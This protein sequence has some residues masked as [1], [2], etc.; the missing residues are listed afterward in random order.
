MV[1]KVIENSSTF[2]QIFSKINIIFFHSAGK[3]TVARSMGKILHGYGVLASDRVEETSATKLIGTAVGLTKDNVE[4]A[5]NL[6]RGGVL[7]IDEAYELGKGGYGDEGMTQLLSMLTMSEFD[8]GKTV[9]ILAGYTTQ[10][11]E[12]L[13]R[14]PGL[15][16]R[17]QKFVNFEDW[18]GRKCAK[19][20]K[21]MAEKEKP[22]PMEILEWDPIENFLEGEFEEARKR[23]GWANAR[24]VILVFKMIVGERDKRIAL[25]KTDSTQPKIIFE[26]VKIA[27]D[28]FLKNRPILVQSQKKLSD[29]DG[30][31]IRTISANFVQ[32]QHRLNENMNHNIQQEEKMEI[33]EEVLDAQIQSDIEKIKSLLKSKEIDD[34]HKEALRREQIRLEELQKKMLELEKQ[35][36]TAELKRL[37][38]IEERRR[39]IRQRLQHMGLC[40]A[41]FVWFKTGTG[42]VCG[43][44][45]HIVSFAD[46]GFT[47]NEVNECG[48]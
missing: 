30:S 42:F 31:G 35:K 2:S 15:K 36:K 41:G 39:R 8:N 17:F 11:H 27:F 24:D 43:G 19:Q 38:E 46:L 48:L 22:K 3:T 34:K 7:F 9:V 16:S 10:M 14:N 33:E 12:M 40:P 29:F 26:D 18:D 4:R 6:A 28:L 45:S 20:I 47:A 44:G 23:A 25:K 13:E 1:A 37:Q 32:P 5:M 21:M